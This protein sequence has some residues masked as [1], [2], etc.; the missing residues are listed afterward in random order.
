[1]PRVRREIR[2]ERESSKWNVPPRVVRCAVR[3][4]GVFLCLQVQELADPLGV[5][6]HYE[7]AWPRQPSTHDRRSHSKQAV[8]ATARNDHYEPQEK[9]VGVL[10]SSQ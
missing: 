4:V 2:R 9:M 10:W 5:Q 6:M 7:A 8:L 3:E 1:M